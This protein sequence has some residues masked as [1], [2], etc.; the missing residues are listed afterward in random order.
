MRKEEFANPEDKT[1]AIV[2]DAAYRNKS[3]GFVLS[4]PSI[5]RYR[6][7]L[8]R[9]RGLLSLHWED[10]GNRKDRRCVVFERFGSA[11]VSPQFY[12]R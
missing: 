5:Q 10:C 2:C 9:F 6:C 7:H 11:T 3:A 8:F 12:S 4:I 1:E